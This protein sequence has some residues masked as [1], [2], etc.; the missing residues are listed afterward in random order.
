MLG[1]TLL[2]VGAV[3]CLNG[4]WLLEKI[5]DREI[6]IVNFFAG[7]VTLLVS[8]RL[9]FGSDADSASIKAGALTLLFTFHLFLGS[10]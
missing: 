7:G 8:L 9:I 1:L 10:A 2:Y 4:L 3:L 6:W 5:G